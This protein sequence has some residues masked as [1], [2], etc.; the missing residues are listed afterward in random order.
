[1]CEINIICLIKLKLYYVVVLF[2][3]E[4]KQQIVEANLNSKKK[5][6]RSIDFTLKLKENKNMI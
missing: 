2:E 1:M 3:Q 6:K 5:K 4:N